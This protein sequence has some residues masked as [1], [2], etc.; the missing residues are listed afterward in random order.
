MLRK[1]KA[2]KDKS[3]DPKSF[4]FMNKNKVIKWLNLKLYEHNNLKSAKHIY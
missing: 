4:L 2:K 1:E 3:I